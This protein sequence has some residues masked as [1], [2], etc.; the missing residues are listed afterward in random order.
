MNEPVWKSG[1]PRTI[2]L[3]TDLSARSDRALDRAVLL[4]RAWKARLVALTVVEDSQVLAQQ[5]ALGDPPPWYRPRDPREVAAAQLRADA[6]AS[7]VDIDIRVEQGNAGEWILDVAQAEGCSLIVTGVARREAL[8]RAVLGSTVDRLVRHARVPVLVVQRR[9]R[10]DYRGLLAASDWSSSSRY[11]LQAA[12]ELFPQ[13]TLT[14][15]HGFD[16]PFLGM[17]DTRRDDAIEQA[18]EQARAEG[19]EFLRQ[20]RL[21]GGAGDV[22]LVVERGDPAQ[23]LPQYAQQHPADLAV[24]GTHG[25][26]ALFDIVLGSVARRIL[27]ASPID[28]LVVRDPR[29]GEGQRRAAP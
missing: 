25:R 3:A 10:Q 18:G 19:M 20:C 8:G 24:L 26:S 2:L 5:V 27:E 6:A 29:A 14:V 7:D 21:P 23:L 17:M 16:V 13:A 1:V 4:A 22:R 11:A 28:T 15:L 9:A 12:T